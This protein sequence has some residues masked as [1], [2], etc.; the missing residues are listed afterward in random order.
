MSTEH[1]RQPCAILVKELDGLLTGLSSRQ[2]GAPLTSEAGGGKLLG[3]ARTGKMQREA[4]VTFPDG[5]TSA[6]PITEDAYRRL[7]EETKGDHEVWVRL[8]LELLP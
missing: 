4:T 8:T 6:V 7:V 2:P 3:Y 5:T 1:K